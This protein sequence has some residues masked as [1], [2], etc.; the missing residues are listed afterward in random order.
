M[1][2]IGSDVLWVAD[3][4]ESLVEA[5]G[6]LKIGEL[7]VTIHS[8]W[9]IEGTIMEHVIQ[10]R[11]IVGVGEDEGT[12]GVIDDAAI[13]LERGV[14]QASEEEVTKVVGG[15]LELMTIDTSLILIQSH[16]TSI[17]Y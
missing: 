11:C 16:D 13:R 1:D 10:V 5:V 17:I 4:L 7:T 9:T 2:G 14:E 8:P 12:R 15:E 3:L 6:E